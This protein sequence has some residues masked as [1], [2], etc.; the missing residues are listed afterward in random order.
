MQ[1]KPG[2][3][4]LA[5]HAGHPL[6]PG[7]DA[8]TP[9]IHLSTTFAR[10][11]DGSYRHP[12]D[13][14]RCT[15]PGRDNLERC[16]C[17]LEGGRAAAAVASGSAATA[18]IFLAL[19]PGAH[20]V[21]PRDAYTGT[22][23]LLNTLFARWQLKSTFVDMTDLD[24]VQKA[25][26]IPNTQ[27][28]W[29]ETPSNPLL[30]ISD[31]A[32]ISEMSHQV[33]AKCV[34]DNTWATPVLQ[35]PL[36]LGADLVTHSSTKYL[37]GHGDAMGGGIISRMENEFFERIRQIQVGMGIGNAPFD[38]WL[39]L[40][41]IQTLPLRIKAGSETASKI[42]QFLSNHP[43]VKQVYYPGLPEHP[44]AKLAA[45]QM[46]MSGGMV[47]FEVGSREEAFQVAGKFQVFTSATSLGITKS[48]VEIGALMESMNNLDTSNV[49][50][51]IPDTLLRLS[52]GIED[53]NTLLWD[54]EQ[55]LN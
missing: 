39:I 34:C 14:I 18:S 2:I 55:A 7:T 13:Y 12:Y 11:S 51:I 30:K 50:T 48:L 16:L 29:L 47:S 5:V 36:E 23:L 53:V 26:S 3:E 32:T 4:T 8:V 46:S 6:D 40:R 25:I 42:A 49:E 38:A 19:E 17:D 33:G 9:A 22:G 54:I 1:I 24:Q 41:G 20:V 15:N 10:Q 21:V 43:K 28:V 31:I 52:V 27:L 44:G 35:R 45:Q 37:G